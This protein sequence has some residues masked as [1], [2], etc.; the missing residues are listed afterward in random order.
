M[1]LTL[2]LSF[3]PRASL[4]MTARFINGVSFSGPGDALPSGPQCGGSPPF[5]GSA[6]CECTMDR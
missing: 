6:D 4:D 5:T 2:F 1:F 3:Q